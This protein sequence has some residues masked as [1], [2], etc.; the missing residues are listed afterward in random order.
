MIV[1]GNFLRCFGSLPNGNLLWKLV[2]TPYEGDLHPGPLFFGLESLQLNVMR[3]RK[4][5]EAPVSL[6]ETEYPPNTV[7][8]RLS[9]HA[10]QHLRHVH[11]PP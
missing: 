6:A 4:G 9:T 11:V 10:Q 5:I 3:R 8:A 1:T 2:L 7:L